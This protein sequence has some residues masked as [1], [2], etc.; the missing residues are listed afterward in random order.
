[1]GF[2]EA[3]LRARVQERRYA[4][5]G[6]FLLGT[7]FAFQLIGY[8]WAFSAWWMIGY[9]VGIAAAAIFLALL[10]M[11]KIGARFYERATS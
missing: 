2:N 5:S 7:G 11:R 10:A 6:A 1:V 4:V 3:L 8:A 9:A